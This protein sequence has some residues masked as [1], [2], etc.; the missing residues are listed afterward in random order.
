M[1]P[2]QITYFS[3]L[4]GSVLFLALSLVTANLWRLKLAHPSLFIAA[5]ISSFWHIAI[6]SN[7]QE[8]FTLGFRNLL[9][10]EVMRYGAWITAALY[11]LVFSTGQKLPAKFRYIIHSLWLIALIAGLTNRFLATP[12]VDSSTAIIWTN[13]VL[14]I[15]ALIA[16]EQLYRNTSTLRL[17]K[18]W[19]I[20]IGA[21]FVYDIYLFSYSLIFDQIDTELWQA[22]GAING[23]A[24]LIIA[25]GSL[26]LSNTS[27]RAKL[28][29]S[30]PAAFY[31]TSMTVAGSIL[32]IMAIGGYYV[33]LYGGNWG[34]IVQIILLFLTF[35]AIGIVFVSQAIRSRISVWINK[36][37]FRHKYDYRLEWLRLI[38]YLSE[39]PDAQDIHTRA[40]T[41][42]ASIFKSPRG[43]LWINQQGRL[44][45][46]ANI[47]MPVPPERREEA[48]DSLFCK[49]LAEQE[50]VF[51]KSSP[52]NSKFASLNALLPSWLED[53]DDLWLV[54]PLLTENNLV[55]FMVLSNPPLDTTLTWE[56]LDLLKTV[57][58]QIASYLDRH[59]ATEIIAES[60]QFDAFN[61]LTAFIMHDLK[62][63]I[64]QQALVVENAAKHKDN[65]AFIEDAIK[66]IDNS[67][68][69][70]SNLLKKLQRN[71]NQEV[72]TLNIS[73]V[74]IEASKKCKELRPM[75]TLRLE[76]KSTQVNADPDQ[77]TMIFTHILKNAQEA[78]PNSGFIDVSLRREDNNAII[79]IEDNGEGMDEAFIRDHLFKPFATTKSGKGMGIG[80]YQSREILTNIGGDMSVESSP[81][82][83]SIFTLSIPATLT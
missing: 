80:V 19:S 62:N 46:I 49:A 3:Y 59:Q 64:A 12:I 16:I 55:G 56:D 29:L 53:V 50:W 24:A 27:R 15:T 48:I 75:P 28:T 21:I 31:T 83:G 73:K 52:Q 26:A 42:V 77:L 4:S 61:K 30:R 41:A 63:L 36:N 60:R 40:I 70:M 69:R 33:Q 39:T 17:M 82:E 72:R 34:T 81:G 11:S 47:N 9:I 74:L 66:T 23:I 37:F 76:D 65:P 5:L 25:I 18:L 7:Y 1:L 71:E 13:L 44:V 58:R 10:L 2:E 67:V 43:A 6:A 32:A 14:A 35:I 68:V 20:S 38:N 22:R 54:L 79:T 45:P 51:S 8:D 78:T 57:G